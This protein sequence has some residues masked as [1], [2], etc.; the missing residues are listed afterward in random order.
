MVG[1]TYRDLVEG[2]NLWKLTY[3]NVLDAASTKITGEFDPW[4]SLLGLDEDWGPLEAYFAGLFLLLVSRGVDAFEKKS[5]T[6][7]LSWAL[8]RHCNGGF[9]VVNRVPFIKM[10]TDYCEE[11]CF[12]VY[13]HTCSHQLQV[14]LQVLTT[15]DVHFSTLS[16]E[17]AR[18]VQKKQPALPES[19]M[20]TQRC[21]V[22]YL[23]P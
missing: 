14:F 5:E 16:E 7:F 11:M 23:E 6:N 20:I 4:K 10:R 15:E 12:Q 18:S 21:D 19:L 9:L 17:A 8:P 3:L 2:K 1:L 13:R 22:L